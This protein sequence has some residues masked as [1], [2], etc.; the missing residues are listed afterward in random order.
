MPSTSNYNSSAYQSAAS[1]TKEIDG[2][3]FV[4]FATDG[5][6]SQQ[7]VLRPIDSPIGE[8]ISTVGPIYWLTDDQIER[9]NDLQNPYG[10]KGA[11]NIATELQDECEAAGRVR[12]PLYVESDDLESDHAPI[13]V[14]DTV[15]EYVERLGVDPAV[16]R[17]Y[18]SG[19]RSFH[20]HLPAY[21]IGDHL[22][23]L[24]DDARSF[25]DGRDVTIDPA[26]YS[27]KRQFRLPGVIHDRTGAPK[28]AID[29]DAD[30]PM[31]SKR[32]QIE[33]IRSG[34]EKPETYADY[35]RSV[36]WSEWVPGDSPSITTTTSTPYT[37]RDSGT[38]TSVSD[39]SR[40]SVSSEGG[41]SVL[42]P[43]LNDPH[44]Q[45]LNRRR[46]GA[47]F[48][49]Y[50]NAGNGD[51]SVVVFEA[52]GD[53]FEENGA[54]Y[55]PAYVLAGV[56]CDPSYT[57]FHQDRPVKLSKPDVDKRRWQD[58]DTVVMIG[59]RS[60]SSLIY[61]L[62]YTKAKMLEGTLSGDGYWRDEYD[63]TEAKADAID[64]LKGDWFGFDVGSSGASTGRTPDERPQEPMDPSDPNDR[65]DAASIRFA[66]ENGSREPTYDDMV[67]VSCR[68]LRLRGWRETVE[69]IA[70]VYGPSFDAGRTH[71]HLTAI[72][73]AYP[74]SFDV[75]VP[76]D[77]ID[78][79]AMET[80]I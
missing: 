66:I 64:V 32:R 11:P 19:G 61:D 7:P 71:S 58:G 69:W 8:G 2:D 39:G 67:R 3:P 29:I 15:K 30:D 13:D 47:V 1:T 33:A 48:S 75:S 12:Y 57:V 4:R 14:L 63:P 73:G 36:R 62:S 56:G 21:T 27:S 22:P 54:M 50:A 74:E 72:V 49:P 6:Q 23:T 77:P 41:G 34:D 38:K 16:C 70:D 79:V 45:E 42:N 76:D 46:N 59:G 24:R 68:L 18:H 25:N 26:V 35:W 60:R 51:R 20:A 44:P 17:W 65:T 28:L 53:P 40:G 52:K 10:V 31:P 55:V 78:P 5:G 9:Q 37:A 80:S 43:Y